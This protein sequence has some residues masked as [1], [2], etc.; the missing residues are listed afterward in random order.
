[1]REGIYRVWFYN[2]QKSFVMKF[3]GGQW[4]PFG[5]DSVPNDEIDVT[6][7]KPVLLMASSLDC[8]TVSLIDFRLTMANLSV[9]EDALREKPYDRL[10]YLA[11][12]LQIAQLQM[13]SLR[14]EAIELRKFA[15]YCG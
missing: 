2:N 5:C 14:Q 4:F 10:P 13:E 7:R 6:G 11:G 1:M 3:F 12:V 9:A 15:F 8:S